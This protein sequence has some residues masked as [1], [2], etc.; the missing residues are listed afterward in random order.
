MGGGGLFSGFAKNWKV[1]EA[2]ASSGLS[3]LFPK[4]VKDDYAKMA[5]DPL[6]LSGMQNEEIPTPTVKTVSNTTEDLE[7]QARKQSEAEKAR[8]KKRK[9]YSSTVLTTMG[10]SLSDPT[11]LKKT[12]GG[13]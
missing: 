10:G 5:L 7:E 4:A 12:L 6:N 3:L 11:V 2:L 9:G 1:G 13:A 8:L